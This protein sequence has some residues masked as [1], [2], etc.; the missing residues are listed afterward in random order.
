MKAYNTDT[1]Y[2][3]LKTME[4][5]GF[6][7]YKNY[8][9]GDGLFIFAFGALQFTLLISAYKWMSARVNVV[10]WL[11]LFV[12]ILRG[13]CDA[14]ENT[15]LILVLTR[16]PVECASLIDISAKATFLKLLLIRIWAVLFIAGLLLGIKYKKKRIVSRT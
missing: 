6:N 8:F 13:I 15:L 11:I 1:V 2:T 9:I 5:Q 7:I 16:Y 12:P 14:V 4:P 3:V 10:K